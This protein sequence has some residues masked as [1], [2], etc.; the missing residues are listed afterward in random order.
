MNN[1]YNLT[2]E[3]R[4]ITPKPGFNKGINFEM[5]KQRRAKKQARHKQNQIER[6]QRDAK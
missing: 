5:S 6:R 4:G 3:E 1:P 2:L